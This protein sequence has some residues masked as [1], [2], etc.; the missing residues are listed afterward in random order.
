MRRFRI[1]PAVDIMN[2][3]CVQLVQGQ[4]E[5]ASTFGDPLEWAQRWI[6]EGATGLHIVN[7]DGAFGQSKAN[8][9][10]IHRLIQ[11][12]GV[13]IQLGGGIRSMED[14]HGWLDTGVSRIILGTLARREPDVIATLSRDYGPERIMAG[15]DAKGDMIVVEG[16][17]REAGDYIYWARRYEALGAGALL[18]T[19]VDVEGLQK[20]I[21]KEPVER[22]VRAVRIPVIA[23]GG[24]S[25]TEDLLLL[26]EVGA[27]GAILGSA[28]YS[29]KI[30]LSEAI[31]VAS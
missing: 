20:G 4:R 12:S 6:E 25:S 14:A 2:G 10:L 30:L 7:L 1:Y 22:I 18:Y 17:Q 28:L 11:E 3:R 29:G 15:V 19:N 31:R 16:W 23:A 21:R 26:R 8:I 5:T 24:I 13:E 9:E 27:G